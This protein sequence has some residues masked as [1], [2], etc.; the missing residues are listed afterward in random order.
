MQWIET[1]AP[2]SG[3]VAVLGAGNCND[4][5]L[6]G[7]L[8]RFREVAL[9]DLDEAALKQAA[10]R[11]GVAGAASL[12]IIGSDLTGVWDLLEQ[13]AVT[14]DDAAVVDR[15]ISLA[16]HPALPKMSGGFD[17]VLSAC[18]LSQLIKGVADA[19]GENHSRFLDLVGAVRSG[20]FRLLSDLAAPG[21][22]IV[23]VTDFVSSDTAPEIAA[24]SESQL[25]ELARRL[26]ENRNFFHGLNPA[27]IA[28]V[29]SRDPHLAATTF[30]LQVAPPWRWDFG[31]RVY[32]VTAFQLE[33]R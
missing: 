20:H 3:R 19:L 15:A 26:L 17:V 18:V 10:D 2:A 1:N 9:L 27:V 7:L 11:Q 6:P 24:A 29:W 16:S 28:D 13:L 32:L 30:N 33:K 4:L 8:S 14:P 23:L 21:G 25:G 5:D 31:P 22:R 12:A